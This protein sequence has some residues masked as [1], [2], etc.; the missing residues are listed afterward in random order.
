MHY[1]RFNFELSYQPAVV[2]VVLRGGVCD[3]FS[4]RI[5][6]QAVG[7]VLALAGTVRTF[8]HHQLHHP[9]GIAAEGSVV[10]AMPGVDPPPRMMPAAIRNGGQYACKTSLGAMSRNKRDLAD[11]V[12]FSADS[13]TL[14][15]RWAGHNS[16][17]GG[18]SSSLGQGCSAFQGILKRVSG[19]DVR[20]STGNQQ[21]RAPDELA[22]PRA[23]RSLSHPYLFHPRQE[24]A[25]RRALRALQR[26][27]ARAGVEGLD[28]AQ[29]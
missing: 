4:S 6:R 10:R 18:Q 16:R 3:Q 2:C 20:V 28:R 19:C 25:R 1:I 8:S 11:S 21:G 5:Q 17:L 13:V 9:E 7:Q 27:A 14:L 29:M 22:L 23:V 12:P 24:A 15:N 26:A